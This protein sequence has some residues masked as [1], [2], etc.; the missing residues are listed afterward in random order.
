MLQSG[1]TDQL[2]MGELDGAAN[3]CSLV[4]FS[5][6]RIKVCDIIVTTLSIFLHANVEK[7]QYSAVN[8]P[9]MVVPPG[10]QEG[11]ADQLDQYGYQAQYG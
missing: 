1:V 11:G 8:A 3:F 6:L 9:N 10:L 2:G 7:Q 4:P 5:H